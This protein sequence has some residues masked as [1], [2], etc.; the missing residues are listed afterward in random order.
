MRILHLITRMILGG[1]QENTLLSV[2]GQVEKGHEVRLVCGPT[3]GPEG[4]LVE[5]A[6]ARGVDYVEIPSLVRNISPINEIRA[7]K[8]I[9]REI[10]EYDPH[11]VHT[12]SSKA[13][14][15]GRYAAWKAGVPFVI[16]TIH[17]LPFHPYQSRI[18][19]FTY[20]KAEKLAARKCHKIACVAD[21]MRDQALAAGVG[22][23]DQY[24]TVYSGM[25]ML[26]F[27]DDSRDATAIRARYG[28]NP[29]DLVIGKI[30]RLFELKGHDYL[31]EAFVEVAKRFPKAKLFLVGDGLWRERLTVRAETL[32]ILDRT[33]FA[34]LIP[35]SEIPDAIY[36]MDMVVHC[37]LREGLARVLPQALL[38]HKPT[39]S[40]AVD[41][42]PEV[43]SD[44]NT[45]LLVPPMDIPALT[46][47]MFRILDD[48]EGAMA[49]A[50]RGRQ[51][52]RK[53]FD[54]RNMCD[55]L[56]EIYRNGLERA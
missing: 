44:R 22:S 48:R 25:E 43:I 7:Y 50:E 16:H 19:Y 2:I 37:S 52:C 35:H 31:L 3:T 14:V 11:V 40:F 30:A 51:R 56:I 5:E 23:K 47:A 1:A 45:G 36:A 15:L 24:E 38:S 39:I 13:G 26:P 4:S 10:K 29:D 33:V 6:I 18:A 46:Q 54:W 34:G 53:M 41:G 9:S 55:R 20:L 8:A 28:L 12:H 27:L 49:M 21:A 32:G 17:G 42:A